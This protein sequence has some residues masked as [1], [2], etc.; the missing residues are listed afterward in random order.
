MEALK[1]ELGA[2][3]VQHIFAQCSN[4]EEADTVDDDIMIMPAVTSDS[5]MMQSSSDEDSL[6]CCKEDAI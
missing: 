6:G 5:D 1:L 4:G 3:T 2:E